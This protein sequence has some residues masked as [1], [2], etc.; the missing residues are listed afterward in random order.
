MLPAAM[1]LPKHLARFNRH[2]TN[3]VLGLVAGRLPWFGIVLHVGRRS[4]RRHRS[5]VNL[6]RTDGRWVIALTY[7]ADAHWVRNVLAAGSCEIQTRGRRVR[8]TDPEVVRDPERRLVPAPVRPFL[9]ALRVTEFM[10]LDD[11]PTA[12]A[13]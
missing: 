4:G 11:A 2:V 3:P 12:P 9:G 5:P 7:G 13:G 10:L 6:F 1:P 8:L